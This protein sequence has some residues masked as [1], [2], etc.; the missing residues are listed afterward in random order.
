MAVPSSG[1]LCF[2]LVWADGEQRAAEELILCGP[3]T[4]IR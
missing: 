1:K 3:H 2:E 4:F